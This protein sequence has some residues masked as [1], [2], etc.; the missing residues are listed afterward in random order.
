M[1]LHD[2]SCRVD[3][4]SSDSSWQRFAESQVGSLK[5]P[6]SLAYQV[7]NVWNLDPSTSHLEVVLSSSQYSGDDAALG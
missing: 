4:R 3:S 2:A 1:D 5:R 6:L 7:L